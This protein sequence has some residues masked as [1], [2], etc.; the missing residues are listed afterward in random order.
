MTESN[1]FGF[2]E[3]SN[4]THN[5]LS[6]ENQCESDLDNFEFCGNSFLKGTGLLDR[7]LS[8]RKKQPQQHGQL[9]DNMICLSGELEKRPVG[10][11]LSGNLKLQRVIGLGL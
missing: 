1:N 5:N 10:I 7:L 9:L 11:F 2:S 3:T 6:S 4:E 8:A